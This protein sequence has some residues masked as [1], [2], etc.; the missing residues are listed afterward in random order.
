MVT[1][2]TEICAKQ[3]SWVPT[4]AANSSDSWQGRLYTE[5]DKEKR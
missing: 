2:S 4:I 5:A 1:K 3:T